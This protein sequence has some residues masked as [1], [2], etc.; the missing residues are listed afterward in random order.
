MHEPFFLENSAKKGLVV[1]VHGFMGSP[2]QFAGL[3]QSVHAMGYSAASLLLPG[4]GSTVKEFSAATMENWQ[5]HVHAEIGRLSCGHADICLVGHSMGGLLA[6]NTAIKHSG[7][8]RCLFLIACPFKL[9]YLS[10]QTIKTK[11]QQAFY[12]KSNP[13]KSAYLLGNSVTL[14]PSL[15]WRFAKPTA[16]LYRLINITKDNLHKVRV[17]VTAVYSSSDE[18]VST[19]SLG[20]LKN[21]LDQ[22]PFES[23][24]LSDSLHAY[25]PEHERSLIEA[26]LINAV[27]QA[28]HGLF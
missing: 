3:A 20:M 23:V 16:E 17:P 14:S 24:T 11:L 8:V 10:V 19:D 28:I 18:T 22:A 7:H 5:D 2:Q 21:R 27:S 25:Y 9:K 15:I 26:A 13:V 6:I 12:R 4:H 1:F